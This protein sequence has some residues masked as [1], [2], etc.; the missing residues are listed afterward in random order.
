MKLSLRYVR[1]GGATS[2]LSVTFD[3]T[4]TV[5]DLAE[6]FGQR[7]P[8]PSHVPAPQP[9]L[10][11]LRGGQWRALDPRV[12]VTESG[13]ASGQA[14]SLAPSEARAQEGAEAVPS[15]TVHVDTGP[16]AGLEFPLRAGSA[17]IGRDRD[18]EV[19]LSDP[20]VS[21]RHARLNVGEAVEIIDLVSS[22]GVEI[23]G[24]LVSRAVVAPA[25]TVLLG[26]TRLSFTRTSAAPSR[27][28]DDGALLF[29]RSPQIEPAPA[30]VV[31]TPPEIPSRPRP[32]A[33]PVIALLLPIL[34]A[35]ATLAITKN[36]ASLLFIAFTPLM[37]VGNAFESRWQGKRSFRNAA[38]QFHD[39]LRVLGGELDAARAEERQARLDRHPATADVVVWVRSL[40][41]RM[42]SRRPD[43]PRFGDVRLGLGTRP[44]EYSVAQE[45]GRQGDLTLVR[46]LGSLIAAHRTVDGVPI[47]ASLR[48]CGSIGVAGPGTRARE[49]ANG[50]LWQ[51]VGMH[52]PV[53]LSLVVAVG[54][55][56]ARAWDWVKWLPHAQDRA[57]VFSG[58][59]TLCGTKASITTMLAALDELIAERGNKS[60][61]HS[62]VKLPLVCVLVDN[63]APV[64]PAR[65]VSLA[66]RGP[67]AG[68]HLLWVSPSVAQLPAA[69]R[70][71]VDLATET[72][73][74][75]VDSG[76]WVD[77]ATVEAVSGADS[78][79]LSR[80]LAPVVDAGALSD[81]Q[82]DI[83]RSVS[84]LDI[85]GVELARSTGSVVDRWRQSGSLPPEAGDEGVVRRDTSLRALIGQSATDPTYI[86]LRSDGP[87]ALVGGTTGAGKS[88]F[89]QTWIL[90]MAAAHSPDRLTF[91]LIDYKGGS[92]FADCVRLPHCVGLVTD[93][94]QQ[95]VRRALLSLHAELTYRE[96]LLHSYRSKD[97]ATM[98]R[99]HRDV[100]PPSLVIVV[101]EF[102]ALVSEVPE[103]VDGVVNVAQRGRSLGLHL[104]LAT[105]RPT[106][107]IKDNL[108]ANTN[109][110][111]ALR[112]AD[113]SDSIDVIGSA[114]AAFFAADIPGRALARSGARRLPPFQTCYVGG[115]TTD[116]PTVPEVVLTENRIGPAQAWESPPSQ[117]P[118]PRDLGLPND[119]ASVVDNIL[120]AASGVGIPPPRKPWLE[121][122]ASL[123][124]L[125]KL[126]TER[127]DDR[128]TFGVA[129]RPGDQAQPVIEFIPDTDGSMVIFGTSGSGKTA[130]LRTM[131]ASAGLAMARG[132]PC[133]VYGFDFAGRGLSMLESLPHVG[134]IIGADDQERVIRTLRWLRSLID[135][136]AKRFAAVQAGN[137]AEYRKLAGAPM[138]PRILLLV[139][140]LGA[141]R[142]AYEQTVLVRWFDVFQSIAADGR[143]VGVHVVATADR[144]GAVPSALG[145]TFQ[146][147]L[148]LR[149]TSEMDYAVM[150][151]RP[152]DLPADGVPGRGLFDAVEV[153]VGLL[154]DDPTVSGQ[155]AAVARLASAMRRAGSAEAPTIYRLPERIGLL[156][157]PTEVAGRTTVG[158]DDETLQPIGI[159]PVGVF[160][161]T[162]PGGSGR[163]LAVET[164]V[165]AL[166]RT[167]EK[168]E[169][170]F[171]SADASP[172]ALLAG[173]SSVATTPE[174]TV[175]NAR[176]LIESAAAGA[177]EGQRILIVVEAIAEFLNSVADDA[178][179][180]LLKQV[181]SRRQFAVV[182][183]ETASLGSSWPLLAAAR[184]GQQGLCLQPDQGDGLQIF[185]TPFPRVSRGDF[186]PGR[187][188][189]VGGGRVTVVQV[190]LAEDAPESTEVGSST[191]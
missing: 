42:W 69:C 50:V 60:G 18:C 31:L 101:D 138:E 110:R 155:S 125:T 16:D 184:S 159:D 20:L 56:G 59:D 144:P 89:L 39:D 168:L 71:F 176:A 9:T 182:E 41:A 185:K 172:T 146:R 47:V 53:E 108:R 131:A 8:A 183:G 116:E 122:L 121:P 141:F 156:S 13:M 87:H 88:E 171:F 113:E 22:N 58:V 158:L 109:L 167:T 190:A 74:G 84:L 70:V 119:I 57:G 99:K 2:D 34:M 43:R 118:E 102:A 68:V 147:R 157:L 54:A 136:R 105:Q 14:V 93:L 30:N 81:D 64:E 162:G 153:Q 180:E 7:D 55:D 51:L 179:Q 160:L 80:R 154:G 83:P 143:Q 37:L 29:T 23:K 106:G 120:A 186:P 165:A 142:S 129:D 103:F 21:K 77:P 24:E 133:Q 33:F 92:A 19:R 178:L 111:I 38:A 11:V 112:M 137:L 10:S 75:L 124:D 27:Q 91:L 73:V 32:T 82:S 164:L 163:T 114:D 97:L 6:V 189:L 78:E 107:V 49:V 98:E 173:W 115:V 181:R 151:L 40:D 12:P 5:R 62:D 117:K 161:V 166:Q 169:A 3:A 123:Y 152:E 132:G 130:T 66:E 61:A 140:N 191:H 4:A 67:A 28:A 96:T 148:V 63:D 139:D 46:E 177:W 104:I 127:R 1:P 52:S 150:G 48:E 25:D 135:D 79:E 134:S 126:P 26:D 44:A 100:A 94:S 36:V 86:D 145:S 90:G 174:T 128:L 149:L 72:V 45:A 15:L 35:G 17:I 85:V 187:G 65:L 188:L 170:H 175:A 76:E 95:L